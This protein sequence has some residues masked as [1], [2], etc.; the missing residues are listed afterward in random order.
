[1]TS[2]C[3]CIVIWLLYVAHNFPNSLLY[4]NIR[5]ITKTTVYIVTQ[6]DKELKVPKLLLISMLGIAS[7]Y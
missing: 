6:E 4:Y 5:Y 1:M 7:L 2:V 3:Y